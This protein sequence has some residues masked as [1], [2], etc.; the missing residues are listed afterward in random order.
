[1][2][3]PEPQR[4]GPPHSVLKDIT[5]N[6]FLTDLACELFFCSVVAASGECP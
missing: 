1:M 5:L 2:P 4:F 3:Q 6:S